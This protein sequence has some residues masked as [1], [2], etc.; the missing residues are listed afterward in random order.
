MPRTLKRGP[1][2]KVTTFKKDYSVNL[3]STF[4]NVS[5]SFVDHTVCVA[6]PTF[7]FRLEIW[8]ESLVKAGN[9][10]V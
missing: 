5:G 2:C 3:P 8:F 9:S 6:I 1:Q 10:N 7:D 4:L